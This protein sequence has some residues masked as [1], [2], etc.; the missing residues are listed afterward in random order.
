VTKP[1]DARRVLPAVHTLAQAAAAAGDAPAWAVRAAAREAV[2]VARA[3]LARGATAAE[4]AA[5]LA[6]AAVAADAARRA[7]PSLRPV[8]NATGVVL[9]TGLGRA[10]LSDAAIG[11]VADAAAGYCNLELDLTTGERG[12]R[13]AHV[14][15]LLRELTGAEAAVVVN[16]NAAAAVLALAALAGDR[17]VVV[18]RGELVEIGGAFRVPEI[19]ALS[20]CQLVEVG[21]TNKTRAGDYATALSPRTALLLKVHRSNFE[22]RGFT[23]E[24]AAS[25]L[26]ALARA[27][28]LLSMF[29]LGSGCL[30]PA[31]EQRALG[32]PPA[33]SVAE[34]VAAGLDVVCFSGDKLL[35]GPQAGIIVGGAA[36]LARIGR[37]PLMRALRPDKLTLAALEATLRHYRDGAW[38]QVPTLAAIAAPRAALEARAGR[39]LALLP[40]GA[41]EQLAGASAIGGGAM[42]GAEQPTVLVALHGPAETLAARLRAAPVPVIARIV[43]GR[44]VLDVRTIADDELALVAAAVGGASGRDD[45][46]AVLR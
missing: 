13:H 9:H 18:S 10:P 29:D 44:V 21:T 2:A 30:L 42:P 46:G 33:V 12:T 25:E 8:I 36:A 3:A 22:L 17:E 1:D 19:L 14:A 40:A 7:L 38:R 32:L 26:A 16:N 5:G 11:A 45:A 23:E 39:L 41:G 31:A 20:R 43:D 27:H 37:H 4:V 34:A 6:P 15:D 28:G 24:V 35:G